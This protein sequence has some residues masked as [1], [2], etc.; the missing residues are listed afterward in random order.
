[1][2]PGIQQRM[3]MKQ[4]LLSALLTI[5]LCFPCYALTPINSA[6]ADAAFAQ[7]FPKINLNNPPNPN[8][9]TTSST[10]PAS[11]LWNLQD[12]DIRTLI[13]QVSKETG[14]NFIVDPRVQGKVTFVSNTPLL[15][16]EL[17]HVFLAILSTHGFAATP[18]R[19]A[20]KI[21][22][23]YEANFQPVPA[24]RPSST[25][26]DDEFVVQVAAIQNL[27][28]S[29]LATTLRP[30]LPPSSQIVAYPQTNSLII[31]GAADKMAQIDQIIKG[32]DQ[33]TASNIEIIPLHYAIAT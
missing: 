14:K 3:F 5:G 33:P 23:I 22:P 6:A 18:S 13:D 17:Y 1:M 10:Q 29:Q 19:N 20:I 4:Q 15:S 21:V 24:V 7:N 32:L 26:T 2:A 27:N 11:Q 25:P 31:S 30:L 16:D 28:A 9:N 8:Q 12:V